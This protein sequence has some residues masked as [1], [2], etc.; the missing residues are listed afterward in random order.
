MK[1]GTLLEGEFKNDK[2]H[3]MALVREPD[4]TQYIGRF[5]EG[6]RQGIGCL[7]NKTYQFVGRFENGQPGAKGVFEYGTGH[8]HKGEF[9]N[10]KLQGFGVIENQKDG[11]FLRGDF[12]DGV[13]D[14]YGQDI[15]SQDKYYEGNFVK[16][17]RSGIGKIHDKAGFGYQGEFKDGKP[18]GFGIESSTDKYVYASTDESGNKIGDALIIEGGQ[19]TVGTFVDGKL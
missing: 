15:I 12:V 18:H 19:N 17:V 8:I 14:G 4:G 2:V 11:S 13:L 9:K 16:G 6:K 10:G 1:D 3:G 7:N 5:S